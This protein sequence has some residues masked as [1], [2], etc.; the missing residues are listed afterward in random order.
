MSNYEVYA[1]P[2]FLEVTCPKHRNNMI[3]LKNGLLGENLWWCDSCERPY[4]LKPTAMKIGTFDRKAVDE[5]L[6]EI[7]ERN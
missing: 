1:R 5:Q 3:E 7:K 2:F 4:H 6:K